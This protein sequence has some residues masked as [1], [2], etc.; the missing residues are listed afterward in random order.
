MTETVNHQ[1]IATELWTL[2]ARIDTAASEKPIRDLAQERLKIASLDPVTQTLIPAEP[3]KP[4]SEQY[5]NGTGWVSREI[6]PPVV[7]PPVRPGRDMGS[8]VPPARTLQPHELPG[9]PQQQL[10]GTYSEPSPPVALNPTQR[11]YSPE[12]VRALA[13]HQALMKSQAEYREAMQAEAKRLAEEQAHQTAGSPPPETVPTPVAPVAPEGRVW[14]GVKWVAVTPPP[15]SN[16][17]PDRPLEPAP[18]A[19]EYVAQQE[20]ALR[21]AQAQTGDG[22]RKHDGGI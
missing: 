2:L 20:A 17:A 8:F 15:P 12:Q 1:K 10:A 16:L 11:T 13:A 3:P 9:S 7:Q 22:G 18:A 19:L 6:A 14:D 21:R 4:A 5:W